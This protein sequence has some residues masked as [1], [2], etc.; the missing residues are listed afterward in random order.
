MNESAGFATVAE[1]SRR[2][3][4][5]RGITIGRTGADAGS[6]GRAATTGI[7]EGG[8]APNPNAAAMMAIDAAVATHVTRT[9]RRRLRRRVS[10]RTRAI[11]RAWAPERSGVAGR[12]RA[13]SVARRTRQS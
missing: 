10:S 8:V 3:G 9:A 7:A 1:K 4:G 11:T 12:F 13:T 6:V 5:A 2:I